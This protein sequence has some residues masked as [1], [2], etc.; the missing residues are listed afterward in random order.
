[1]TTSVVTVGRRP[2]PEFLLLIRIIPIVILIRQGKKVMASIAAVKRYPKRIQTVFHQAK[3]A[4]LI[5][6]WSKTRTAS[7]QAKKAAVHQANVQ[8]NM[9]WMAKELAYLREKVELIESYSPP[10]RG[11]KRGAPAGALAPPPVKSKKVV[12]VKKDPRVRSVRK[13]IDDLVDGE[14]MKEI[15]TAAILIYIVPSLV[16]SWK[17]APAL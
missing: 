15:K 17:R 5:P 8:G 11:E 16:S 2:P 6:T 13:E 14:M 10:K 7:H 1:M 3:N 9:N 12:N 4:H